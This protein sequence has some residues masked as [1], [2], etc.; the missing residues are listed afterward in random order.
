MSRAQSFPKWKVTITPRTSSP[1][2]AQPL[3]RRVLEYRGGCHLA[4]PQEGPV[5]FL[6]QCLSLQDLLS[7]LGRPFREYELWALCL[8]CLHALQ[9]HAEPPGDPAGMG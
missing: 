5:S 2:P 1:S 3:L 8:T 9:T 4:S 7:K 6:P